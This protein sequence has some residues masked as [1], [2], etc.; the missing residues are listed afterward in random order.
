MPVEVLEATQPQYIDGLTIG[1]SEQIQA[2]QWNVSAPYAA[3][4]QIAKLNT[5]G[6]P[7]WDE[8]ELTAFPGQG[9]YPAC[10]GIRFRSFK[11]GTNPTTVLCDGYFADDPLPNGFIAGNGQF[12]TGGQT[13]TGMINGVVAADGTILSGTGFTVVHTGSGAYTVTITDGTVC[14]WTFTP[15][16]TGFIGH[17]VD[18]ISQPTSSISISLGNSATRVGDDTPFSFVALAAN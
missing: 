7:A 4:Y 13:S 12:S 2:V 15:G 1:P 8:N 14:T 10:F 11:G 18:W 17:Y 6:K 5:T 16:A 9:G 3:T